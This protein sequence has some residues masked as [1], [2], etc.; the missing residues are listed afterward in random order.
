MVRSVGS[1]W[2]AKCSFKRERLGTDMLCIRESFQGLVKTYI[3]RT[4]LAVQWLTLCASS[5]SGAG[6]I[7]GW[8][9]KIPHVTWH[10]QNSNKRKQTNKT[11]TYSWP[12]NPRDS[13]SVDPGLSH[14][15]CISSDVIC[16]TDVLGSQNTPKSPDTGHMAFQNVLFAGPY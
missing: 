5:V 14:R 10:S 13:D 11:P 2:Y 8:G 16:H 4:S 15:L 7:P 3:S 9:T 6:S 1:I 12:T